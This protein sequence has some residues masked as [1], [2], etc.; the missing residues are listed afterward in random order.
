MHNTLNCSIIELKYLDRLSIL[1][2]KAITG[3]KMITVKAP[4]GYE[5]MRQYRDGSN[6]WEAVARPIG[7]RWWTV[8]GII[9]HPYLSSEKLDKRAEIKV[10][11]WIDLGM[12]K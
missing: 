4:E 9:G 10:A 5:A 8:C 2:L 1:I 12:V 6:S 7:T 3:G 11:Q